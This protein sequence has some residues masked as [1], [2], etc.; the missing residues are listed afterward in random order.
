M[1]ARQTENPLD[2]IDDGQ[3]TDRSGC[4]RREIPSKFPS[5]EKPPHK[6]KYDRKTQ[7][8]GFPAAPP[9]SPGKPHERS[10]A[11]DVVVWVT[12]Q[13][14]DEGGGGE[15]ENLLGTGSIG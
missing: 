12:K 6:Q 4:V 13:E 10:K 8:K 15:R 2:M 1:V 3:A 5:S 14:E 7:E 11:H 9:P